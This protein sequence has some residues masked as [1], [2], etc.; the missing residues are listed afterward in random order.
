MS[1]CS[2]TAC[3]NEGEGYAHVDLTKHSP[4][5][6]NNY[7]GHCARRINRENKKRLIVPADELRDAR[8]RN[9]IARCFDNGMTV[10]EIARYLDSYP[11]SKTALVRLIH[12]LMQQVGDIDEDRGMVAPAESAAKK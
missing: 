4:D 5:K 8:L 7:C 10:I 1:K 11:A 12:G 3:N 6:Y 2:R 9:D